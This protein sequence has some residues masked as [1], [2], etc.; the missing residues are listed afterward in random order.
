[1]IQCVTV[2]MSWRCRHNISL[3]PHAILDLRI[4]CQLILEYVKVFSSISYEQYEL[5]ETVLDCWL[6]SRR[7]MDLQTDIQTD[8]I[9][10]GGANS[11]IFATLLC[12]RAK[13]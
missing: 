1:M 11:R 10:G 13:N 12:K 4:L 7:E 8:I 2:R 3:G 9:E 5:R 6:A